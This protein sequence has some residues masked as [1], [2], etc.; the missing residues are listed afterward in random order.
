M[1]VKNEE[2]RCHNR[3]LICDLSD[4]DM[5]W[6]LTLEE[7]FFEQNATVH[8]LHS[9]TGQT[10]NNFR[11]LIQAPSKDGNISW[12]GKGRGVKSAMLSMGFSKAAATNIDSSKIFLGSTGSDCR[13]RVTW[14]NFKADKE[15]NQMD[16]TM[17]VQFILNGARRELPSRRTTPTAAARTVPAR[18][19]LESGTG[20]DRKGWDD[21][22]TPVPKRPRKESNSTLLS[23]P[24]RPSLQKEASGHFG[25]DLRHQENLE[26]K[27]REAIRR[28]EEKIAVLNEEV[29]AL[30]AEIARL[31]E[32][33]TERDRENLLLKDKAESCIDV[34]KAIE[35]AGASGTIDFATGTRMSKIIDAA[36]ATGD[37]RTKAPPGVDAFILGK[38]LYVHIRKRQ[39]N[40]QSG[41]QCS[42]Q[43]QRQG[44]ILSY[45]AQMSGALNGD[46]AGGGGLATFFRTNEQAAAEAAFSSHIPLNPKLTPSETIEA[47]ETAGATYKGLQSLSKLFRHTPGY[48]PLGVMA[49]AKEYSREISTKNISTALVTLE[50]SLEKYE[51]RTAVKSQKNRNGVSTRPF[52]PIVP[53]SHAIPDALHLQFGIGNDGHRA[54][55]VAL[56]E[57]D[58]FDPKR[59]LRL[60]DLGEEIAELAQKLVES[61]SGGADFL[62]ELGGGGAEA[63]ERENSGVAAVSE[64][65]AGEV[66][67][68]LKQKED[69]TRSL[70][71]KARS[72]ELRRQ[73]AGVV[74]SR[75]R[76]QMKRRRTGSGEIR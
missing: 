69:E 48:S 61:R 60:N 65:G 76:R 56:T 42:R 34:D 6:P 2:K 26:A 68:A 18:V 16:D 75:S 8:G 54:I 43:S 4:V 31:N 37:S 67:A 13:N 11:E 49:H 51:K 53:L 41:V 20:L 10:L 19:S 35:S 59:Q 36:L 3:R 23:E 46:G 39:K 74:T 52:H 9:F 17:E 27:F 73:E 55:K 63:L 14:V 72:G 45:V 1:E 24:P 71:E 7:A 30:N 47:F 57:L 12:P 64:G 28:G 33:L 25:E 66:Y 50:I 29:A 32:S 62:D 21:A 44:R 70:A 40:P 58:G 38:A 5:Y 15:H 22:S